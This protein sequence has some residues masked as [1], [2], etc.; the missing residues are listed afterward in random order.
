MGRLRGPDAAI[1]IVIPA[2]DAAMNVYF[3]LR[4]LP[5]AHEVVLVDCGST[6]G[7]QDV[8]RHARPDVRVLDRPGAD[9]ATALAAGLA[10]AS[11]DSIVTLP[12]DGSADPGEIPSFV[13]ALLGGADLVKGSRYVEGGSALVTAP[14]GALGDRVLTWLGRRLLGAEL[15]DLGYGF[16]A[17]WADQRDLLRLPAGDGQRTGTWAG[18]A[19]VAVAV[20]LAGAG[21]TVVE[22]PTTEKAPLVGPATPW[23]E[24]GFVR[25]VRTVLA[26]RRRGRRTRRRATEPVPLAGPERSLV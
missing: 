7:T 10:A 17:F 16:Y 21:A 23:G 12:V 14:G 24:G 2:V 18:Q 1:S 11:G 25:G 20:R 3:V 13:E 26:E 6:D 4:Q 8:A 9:R 15:T 5:E 22:V 19:D